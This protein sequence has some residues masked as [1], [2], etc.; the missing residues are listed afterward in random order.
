MRISE[1][2]ISTGPLQEGYQQVYSSSMGVH[3]HCPI[4]NRYIF[5]ETV[6][7]YPEVSYRYVYG[8]LK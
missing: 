4:A 8:Q 1:S 2:K 7:N 5:V 3:W 6:N